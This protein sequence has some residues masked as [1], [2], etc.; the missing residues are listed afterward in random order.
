MSV[1][2]LSALKVSL[3][4][5]IAYYI[6][7]SMAWDNPHWAALSVAF[8]SLATVGESLLKGMLRTFGTFAAIFVA[9]FLLALFPQDRWIFTLCVSLWVAFCTWKMHAN[10]NWYFWF[11]A[12]LGVP[13]MSM[14]S[15]GESLQAFQTVVL[16]AQETI[17]GTLVF[18]VVSSL[19]FP[20][21][22]KGSFEQDI[23]Q[24]L[25]DIHEGIAA[26]RRALLTAHASKDV[27]NL[28]P[29]ILKQAALRQ[30][31]LM[32]KLEAA[33]LDSFDLSRPSA[34]QEQ[35]LGWERELESAH[36]LPQKLNSQAANQAIGWQ[37]SW[38]QLVNACSASEATANRAA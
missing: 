12:G 1:R 4:I 36:D 20:T 7:L 8:C 33:A 30:T 17:L 38:E 31:G 15:G 9:L 10:P 29:D 35:I 37:Q 16:R 26:A 28:P 19:V 6:S 18:T 5:A 24:Q 34:L 25:K 11:C 23:K 13:L 3:S 21:N 14:L 2:F 27:L 32:A 22:T